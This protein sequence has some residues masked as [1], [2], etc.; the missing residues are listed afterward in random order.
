MSS[1]VQVQAQPSKPSQDVTTPPSPTPSCD[2]NLDI[3]R[4]SRCQRSMSLRN[5]WSPEAVRFGMNSYYCTRCA[6]MVG[7]LR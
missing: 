1:S 2:M 6:N 3:V 5:E 4:C 7:Y